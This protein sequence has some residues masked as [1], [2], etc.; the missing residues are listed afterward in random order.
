MSNAHY[1]APATFYQYRTAST[2]EGEEGLG[3]L[4]PNLYEAAR[5]IRASKGGSVHRV[6]TGMPLVA[7]ANGKGRVI[8]VT[9][10]AYPYEVSAINAV[11]AL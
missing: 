3:G 1:E 6:D 4:H 10:N 11:P 7:Q 8:P 9:R 5:H 2:W